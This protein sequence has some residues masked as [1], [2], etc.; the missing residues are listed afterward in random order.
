MNF[1]GSKFTDFRFCGDGAPISGTPCSRAQVAKAL[2]AEEGKALS[3]MN[4]ERT[5]QVLGKALAAVRRGTVLHGQAMRATLLG[6]SGAAIFLSL[7]LF[8]TLRC[9]KL[10]N[11]AINRHL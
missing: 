7:N 10:S 4:G 9:R 3:P 5:A 8:G 1:Y 11:G 2:A 6:L